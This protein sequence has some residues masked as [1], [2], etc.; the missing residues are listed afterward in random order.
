MKLLA[1]VNILL[2]LLVVFRLWK[3][4]QRAYAG[5]GAYLIVSTLSSTILLALLMMALTPQYRAAWIVTELAMAIPGGWISWEA[6]RNLRRVGK[7]LPDAI[8]I[9]VAIGIMTAVS[10]WGYSHYGYTFDSPLE[11]C[12]AL[13][14]TLEF[15]FCVM[16]VSMLVTGHI[17][18]R[19]KSLEFRHGVLLAGYFLLNAFTFFG[20]GLAS[21]QDRLYDFKP[22]SYFLLLTCT[23]CLAGWLALFGRRPRLS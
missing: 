11:S 5:F 4:T 14:A 16:L 7:Q 23:A 12:F 8:T 15:F 19:V 13:K 20:Y 21:A 17:P 9:F 18:H 1:A 10:V 22:L 3:T 2:E 6:M